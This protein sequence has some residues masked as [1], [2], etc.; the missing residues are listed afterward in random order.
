[1]RK[2]SKVAILCLVIIM[3]TGT[4]VSTLASNKFPEKSVNYIICF[5]PGGESDIT[6]RLQHKYL[7]EALGQ[8]VVI[9]YKIGGGGAIGWSEL[10]RSKPDGYTISGDNL[11]HTIVQPLQRKD[12]GYTTEQL[13]RTY[14]FE[15]TPNVLAVRQDSPFK[16]L[17]E[18]VEYAKKYPEA[19]TVGGS[20][21]WSAGHLATIELEHLAD[22]KLTYIPFTGS[23]AAVPALLGGHVSALMTYTS[24][25]GQH[26]EMRVLAV[27]SDQR[28]PVCPDAPTFQECGYDLVEGCYRGVSV[29][30]G[31]PD[32]IVNILAEAF[33]KVNRNPE[34]QSKMEELGYQMVYLGPE[35][36]EKLVREK[37]VY[38]TELLRELDAL[39]K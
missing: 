18:F 26:P 37:T 24:M 30:P 8:K 34:F 3:V 38:Y 19:V 21:S 22:I 23:G 29:P 36:Y 35:E 16:T 11:P 6:A 32:E 5:N 1:M 15:L 2:I 27:A 31:T 25:I 14:C 10:V 20:A 7:E 33:D 4:G 9:V 13:K 17:E 39:A 28:S 12:A